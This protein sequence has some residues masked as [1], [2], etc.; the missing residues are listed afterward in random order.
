MKRCLILLLIAALLCPAAL[1]E[2]ERAALEVT[3]YLA[4]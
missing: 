4:E 3:D 1:A 2:G